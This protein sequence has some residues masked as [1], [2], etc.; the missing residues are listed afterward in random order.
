ML[1]LEA[2]YEGMHK[3]PGMHRQ[4]NHMSDDDCRLW[5]SDCTCRVCQEKAAKGQRTTDSI[6]REYNSIVP[7]DGHELTRHMYLLCPSSIPAFVFKLRKWGES[8]FYTLDCCRPWKHQAN[9]MMARR[10]AREEFLRSSIPG[11]HDWQ[12]SDGK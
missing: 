7:R 6:F 9:M 8:C 1:D 2:C 3:Q 12:S 4:P 10:A 11:R 5:Y